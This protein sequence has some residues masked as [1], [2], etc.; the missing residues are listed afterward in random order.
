MKNKKKTYNHIK[1]ACKA[2]REAEI[3]L[4]GKTICHTRVERNPKAYSRK[5]KHKN[6]PDDRAKERDLEELNAKY[7]ADKKEIEKAYKTV[8]KD[9]SRESILIDNR[10]SL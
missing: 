5:I 7:E 1:N 4:Y 2:H 6:D 8:Y 3:A 9:N 10:Y